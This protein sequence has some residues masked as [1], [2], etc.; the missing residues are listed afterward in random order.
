[1][2]TKVGALGIEITAN[3]ESL[4]AVMKRAAQATT[5]AF[6]QMKADAVKFRGTLAG[7]GL[8]VSVL[9]VLAFARQAIDAAAALD[10]M[11]E[12]TGA[13]VENL[14]RLVQVAR[15]SGVGLETV[16]SALV[17]LAKALAQ[18]DDET[19]GAGAAFAALGL[20][21]EKLRV[22]DTAEALKAL[23]KGFNNFADGQG[24]TAAAIAILG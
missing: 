21:P 16:E 10:D 12:K 3:D 2:A 9:G 13:S 5:S 15:T 6:D 20:D 4:R 17:K 8:G 18:T 22:L 11:A 7:L 1:M 19:R 24:K 23:A 14:S